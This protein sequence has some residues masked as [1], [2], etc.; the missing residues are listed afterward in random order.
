[1]SIIAAHS[2]A[3]CVKCQA[4]HIPRNLDLRHF[5]TILFYESSYSNR[6]TVGLFRLHRQVV[7]HIARARQFG[8][9]GFDRFLFLLGSNL[10][11]ERDL[12][13]AGDIFTLWA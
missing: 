7:D 9:F 12:S 6:L 8:R 4:G 3:R 5:P 10:A 2:G 11:L 1:M 13:F